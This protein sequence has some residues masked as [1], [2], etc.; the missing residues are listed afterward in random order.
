MLIDG[1]FMSMVHCCWHNR[2]MP[3][4]YIDCPE[5]ERSR[6]VNKLHGAKEP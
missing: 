5:S 6:E 2:L 4:S 1:R 3:S